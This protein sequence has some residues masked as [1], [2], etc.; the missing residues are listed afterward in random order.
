MSLSDMKV[1]TAYSVVSGH[2]LKSGACF[3]GHVKKLGCG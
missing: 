3:H 1:S 2:D